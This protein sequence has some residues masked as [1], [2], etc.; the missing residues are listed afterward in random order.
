M[1]VSY[2]DNK[3]YNN[4]EDEIQTLRFSMLIWTVGCFAY[5]FR[6]NSLVLKEHLKQ[7]GLTDTTHAGQAVLK[8]E[9]RKCSRGT[10]PASVRFCHDL[11]SAFPSPVQV[12]FMDLSLS[13][14]IKPATPQPN[15]DSADQTNSWPLQGIFTS[16]MGRCQHAF[17]AN[18]PS[19]PLS[20]HPDVK[21]S[22]A[23]SQIT[24]RALAK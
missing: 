15:A 10:C 9:N 5:W 1:N 19:T 6:G 11:C 18:L 22:R 17:G 16:S 12:A 23:A 20:R 2:S 8:P 21:R 4:T 24:W 3:N 13:S 7:Q 14:L